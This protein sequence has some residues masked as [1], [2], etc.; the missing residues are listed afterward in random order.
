MLNQIEC[1]L[2]IAGV[3]FFTPM[4]EFAFG[5]DL[6]VLSVR[7]KPGRDVLELM[8]DGKTNDFGRPI[9]DNDNTDAVVSYL[10]DGVEENG[11]ARYIEF[12][13]DNCG[14][15][16]CFAMV[17]YKSYHGVLDL[18]KYSALLMDIAVEKAPDEGLS[19][20]IGSYP[21]RAE[22]DIAD[23]LP[24]AGQGWRKLRIELSEFENNAFENYSTSYTEDVLSIGTT[25]QAA[26]KINNVRWHE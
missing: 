7:G 20:R 10:V 19:I 16:V 14:D 26:I 1:R 3:L 8:G 22:I 11:R 18:S 2:W 24:P 12:T 17:F 15:T 9:S 4:A 23:R 25:G 21:S 6:T 5:D 13:G